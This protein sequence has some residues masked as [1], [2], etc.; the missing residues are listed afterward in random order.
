MKALIALEDG[1][2]FEGRSFTGPG[3]TSGEIIF[4]TAM[5]GYQEILTDPSY[6]AQLVT[7]TY[8]LIG[9]Y[10]INDEDVESADIFVSGFVLREYE[11]NYSNWR[12]KISLG[13]YLQKKGIMGVDQVDTRAITRHIRL[14]GAM[15][16]VMSTQDLSPESL[17]EKAKKSPGLSEQNLVDEA[18]CKEPYIWDIK[19]PVPVPS[20]FYLR[21]SEDSLRIAVIDCGLKYNQLRLMAD[22]DCQCIVFPSVVT[23]RELL[24]YDPDGIFLSN[25]PGDPA[26]LPHI[27]ATVKEVLGKRP[28]FGICLGHQ[29]LGQAFG[30]TTYKLKFGHHGANQPVKN[31]KT[32]C[33]EITSQNHGYSVDENSLPSHVE[34]THLNLNDNTVEGIR[35]TSIPAFSVQ[36]HPENAPGPHDSEYLFDEF[37]SMIKDFKG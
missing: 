2:I 34:I 12:A 21:K 33:I 9:N 36:Y 22:R 37:I 10:G 24:A 27:V 4:N 15:K 7:M 23:S 17:V 16:A 35:S 6:K 1:R 13:E 11:E 26:T 28:V 19:G 30:G 31:L 25:G 29:I 3:E 8:P 32:G 5:T 20:D 14:Q 18:S